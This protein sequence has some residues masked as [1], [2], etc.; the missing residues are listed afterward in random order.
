VIFD[1]IKKEENDDEYNYD[2]RSNGSY[3]G[4]PGRSWLHF[5]YNF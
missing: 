4:C 3:Y 1:K 2:A 5:S